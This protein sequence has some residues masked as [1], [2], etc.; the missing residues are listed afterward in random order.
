MK[1]TPELD[2]V[3]ERMQ[4][5]VL[6]LTGYLGTD[7]RKLADI[8]DADARVLAA[9]GVTNEQIASRLAE[10][11]EKGRDI[12]ER[13]VTVEDRYRVRDRDDRGLIPSPWG[14]GLFTKGDVHLTDTETGAEFRWNGVTIHLIRAHGFYGGRGSDY[15]ID[16]ATA[17]DALGIRP[18]SDSDTATD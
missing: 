14:D 1:Q 4:P 2:R 10:L 3:Q 6:T 17:I 12:A 15:R 9:R 16:P 8:L 13:E 5:G 18:D 11:G 7:E